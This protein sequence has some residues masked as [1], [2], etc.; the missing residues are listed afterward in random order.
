MIDLDDVLRDGLTKRLKIDLDTRKFN[1][2]QIRRAA[3]FV[4]S[5]CGY[6]WALSIPPARRSLESR[7]LRA[8]VKKMVKSIVK[9][10]GKCPHQTWRALC[11]HA[12]HISAGAHSKAILQRISDE[13]KQYQ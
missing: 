12:I 2:G 1:H 4:V 8:T 11:A 5:V 9:E 6:E 7:R 3:R 10:Q 13:S